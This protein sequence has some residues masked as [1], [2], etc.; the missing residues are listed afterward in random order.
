MMTTEFTAT[1]NRVR[2]R[3]MLE[4]RRRELARAVQNKIRDGRS[5]GS[6]ELGVIDDAENSEVDIQ[7]DI[8]F[9]LVQM[10]SET[11]HRIDAALR[12]LEDGTYGQCLECGNEIPNTRLRALPFAVRCKVCEEAREMAG[13]RERLMPQRRPSELFAGIID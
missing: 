5:N 3:K 10:K 9:A 4:E 6:T 11:L 2:L 8:G 13:L 1:T 12:R 7:Q